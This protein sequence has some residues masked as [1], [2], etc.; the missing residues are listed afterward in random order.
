MNAGIR[1]LSLHPRT[2]RKGV[3]RPHAQTTSLFGGALRGS[4]ARTCAIGGGRELW[5]EWDATGRDMAYTVGKFYTDPQQHALTKISGEASFSLEVRSLD[6][7]SLAQLEERVHAIANAI[8]A[9][10]RRSLRT[11]LYWNTLR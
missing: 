2:D 11:W 6:A 9:R 5:R 3:Q 4:G 10:P 7:Q 1:S 8:A